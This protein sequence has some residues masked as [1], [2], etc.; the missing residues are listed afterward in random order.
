MKQSLRQMI[1]SVAKHKYLR[2]RNAPGKARAHVN[3]VAYRSETREEKVRGG[4]EFFD[5]SRDGLDAREVK[6]LVYSQSDDRNFVMHKLILS[7]G[8]QSVD[9]KDY[10]RE[11][12]DKLGQ[13]KR[14]DLEWRAVIHENTEHKHAHVILMGKDKNGHQVRIRRE[15]HQFLRKTGDEYLDREHKLDR[16]LDREMNTLLRAKNY[17]R[18]G[19]DRFKSLFFGGNP[20]KDKDKKRDEEAFRDRREFDKLDKDLKKAFGLDE[21]KAETDFGK[22]SKQQLRESQGR[23]SDFHSHAL[24]IKAQLAY[25]AI[26][27]QNPELAEVARQDMEAAKQMERELAYGKRA[28]LSHLFGFDRTQ[29]GQ[30]R[31]G[32]ETWQIAET[33]RQVEESQ[34]PAPLEQQ[35]PPEKDRGDD[36]LD[37]GG[38]NK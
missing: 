21:R 35:K 12:M 23:L 13:E 20:V 6:D 1:K 19:D 2:G 11:V 14:L 36:T 34:K 29:R 32:F 28:D 37:R 30:E 18:G 15:D 3:Y 25:E 7:P 31:A 38:T 27:N 9:M 22:G 10:T 8:V 26:K 5:S 4:R 33:N 16:F 17:D 24:T